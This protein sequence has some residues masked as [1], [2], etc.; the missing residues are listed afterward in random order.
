VA[1]QTIN[2]LARR[3]ILGAAQQAL[4]AA[5]AFGVIPTPLDELG[6][7]IGVQE[8]IDISQLPEDLVLSKPS[9]L[10]KLLGAYVFRAETA[11]V[12]FSQPDGRARFIQGHELGHRIVPWH[13]GAYLDDER[14][15]FRETEDLLEL[16]ANLAGAHL[17]FQGSHFFERALE[18]PVSLKTPLLLASEFRASLH[19]TIRYYVEHHPEPV[20]VLIAGQYT[21]QDGTVPIFLALESAG[22]RSRFGA[23][24]TRFPTGS[25][26]LDDSRPL[27]PL[28]VT[29]RD[30]ADTST[31]PVVLRDRNQEQQRCVAEAFFNQRC[32]FVMFAP[33]TRLRSGRRIRI[34]S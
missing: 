10:K 26:P 28:L 15:L 5:D 3:Q 6:E 9:A 22:F 25:L 13:E 21:R 32:Y 34:A 27:G 16:E 12:D 8:V 4:K 17:I 31:A 7:S 23:I 1:N 11:F 2:E 30:L 19:A 18:F 20:A 33:A 29:A 14:R 24:A